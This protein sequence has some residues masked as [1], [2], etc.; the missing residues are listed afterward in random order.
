[1]GRRLRSVAHRDPG[2]ALQLRRRR[3][4]AAPASPRKKPPEESEAYLLKPVGDSIGAR[5]LVK[6]TDE[7]KKFFN[8]SFRGALEIYTPAAPSA[9]PFPSEAALYVW[10]DLSASGF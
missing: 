5:N 8:S 1:M 7:S 10:A 4:T 2:S 9:G 3:R 6:P